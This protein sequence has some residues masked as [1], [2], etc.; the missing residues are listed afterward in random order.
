[1]RQWLRLATIFVL[2]LVC[3][4]LAEEDLYQ[5]LGVSRT[6]TVKEIKQA[7]RRKALDTH[8]D[9]NKGREE[10][11][12]K[13]FQKVVHAFEILS[14]QTSR[15]RYDR[16]GSTSQ[17]QQ[18]NN[19]GNSGNYGGFSW[20]FTWSSGGGGGNRYHQYSRPKPKLK[21]K[22]QVKEAQ[23]RILHIVSLEQ[24]ETVIVDEDTNTLERNLL[25]VFY[26][27]KLEE[28]LMDE[29]VYPY[30]FAAMSDQGIWWEDLLQTTSVRFHRS[31]ALTQ[32]FN[33]PNGDE[34]EKPI[35]IFGKR[36]QTFD[37][38][39]DHW[40]HLETNSR[41][42]FESWMWEQIKITVTFINRHDHP[43]DIFWI[44]GRRAN[45]KIILQPGE[46]SIHY[47]RL[48]HEWWVRDARTDTHR[49]S[50][51]GWKLT[52]NNCLKTWKITSDEPEQ[53]LVIPLRK[54]YDL[55]GHCSFWEQHRECT[56][57]PSFMKE[58]CAKTCKFCN[59][60]DDPPEEETAEPG[61]HD[62]L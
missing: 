44:H 52:D 57:N 25:M 12:S 26:T 48:S 4:C 59:T 15:Q 49:D 13:D 23:S 6:A 8:P 46:E 38:A 43:V 31:N 47:T 7:Y 60:A 50:P 9:K 51:G 37:S 29:M 16:T 1:M 56:K 34:L 54:C 33:I 45:S 58:Q 2:W 53:L 11:A 20:S 30:P 32:F 28:H 24:L 39:T 5:I 41:T 21:D 17:Q 62:E 35:F 40:A 27:P 10:E 36:G 18:F 61:D 55:S 14:D 19:N 22:F 42:E 3:I